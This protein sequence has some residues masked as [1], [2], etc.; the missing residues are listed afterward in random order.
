MVAFYWRV[1]LLYGLCVREAESIHLPLL[2]HSKRRLCLE[3][4]VTAHCCAK[5]GTLAVS[6]HPGVGNCGAIGRGNNG[7]K[8]GTDWLESWRWTR[9]TV[10]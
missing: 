4:H 3:L 7:C 8:D 5:I 10:I 2:R 6:C 1:Q 9:P